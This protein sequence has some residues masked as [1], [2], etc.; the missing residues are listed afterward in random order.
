MPGATLQSLLG[1]LLGLDGEL[2]AGLLPIAVLDR[3]LDLARLGGKRNTDD[4]EPVVGLAQHH[5]RVA[6]ERRMR[7]RLLGRVQAH[8]RHAAGD[9]A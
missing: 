4:R 8:Q 1:V 7:R 3:D 5:D 9:E 2:D 6:A